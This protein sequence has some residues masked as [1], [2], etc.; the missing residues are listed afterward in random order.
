[1]VF[2]RAIGLYP[3]EQLLPN[4][5][6]ADV[7]LTASAGEPILDYTLVYETAK[8][9][10]DGDFSTLEAL[11]KALMQSLKTTFPPAERIRICIRKYNPPAGGE[12][13]YAQ[14]CLE[15]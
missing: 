9:V 14:V 4:R 1:M 13:G 6:E 12:V 3:E 10:F 8:T 7:D 5:F 11:C 2:R 15:D